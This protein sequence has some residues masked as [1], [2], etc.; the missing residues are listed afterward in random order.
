MTTTTFKKNQTFYDLKYLKAE[1]L[2]ARPTVEHLSIKVPQ[3]LKDPAL[4]T[5][6]YAVDPDAPPEISEYFKNKASKMRENENIKYA[7]AFSKMTDMNIIYDSISKS[8]NKI[9]INEN[10]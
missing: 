4:I 2:T 5:S 1:D 10:I 7:E 6:M 8:E 9:I 3:L